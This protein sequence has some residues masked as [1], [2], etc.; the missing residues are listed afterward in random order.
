MAHKYEVRQAVCDDLIAE[1]G[2]MKE[3]A[4]RH[5]VSPNTVYAWRNRLVAKNLMQ[6][7]KREVKE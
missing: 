4:E 1:R 7:K 5:G 2:T 6:G 3:I